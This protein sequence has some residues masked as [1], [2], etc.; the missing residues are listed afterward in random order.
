L[1]LAPLVELLLSCDNSKRH[2]LTTED[3]GKNP[4]T[5]AWSE[6]LLRRRHG[7]DPNHEPVIR[8]MV[9]Q[10]RDR[11]LDGARL[12]AGKVL[13]DVGAGD[14]LITFGAFE[15]VGPALKAVLTDVSA[16]LLKRAEDRAVERGVRDHCTFLQTSAERLE[17]LADASADVLITRAVLVYVTDK[18]A[19]ARQFHRVL[20]PGGRVSI[21]EPVCRYEALQ[22]AALTDF[23][24]SRPADAATAH[25][26]LLQRCRAA[27]LPS[28]LEEI[29]SNPITN[30]SERELITIFEKAG[31][32]EVHLELHIDVRKAA[33]MPWDTYIDIAPRPGAPTLREVMA[34]QLS[35][36]EQRRFEEGLSPLVESGRN[37]ER[38][39][40]AYL[41][42]VKPV[43]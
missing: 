21:G 6:W 8:G 1:P 32:P 33:A 41:T 15:R 10:I 7:G 16:P 20:K 5:D 28:T 13:V 29:Q 17:G 18:A 38:D 37:M 34:S 2:N 9:E 25:A 30:F 3:T 31:F 14:G 23:L 12:S 22:L 39:T 11:V 27:Q 26:R 4:S 19:A 40:I 42:A 36:S 43:E 24:R 35:E